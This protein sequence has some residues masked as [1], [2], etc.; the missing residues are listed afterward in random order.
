MS[1]ESFDLLPGTLDVIVLKA[2]SLGPMHGWGLAQRIE[3]MSKGALDVGQGSLYPALQ[4]LK[5][6]G[7]VASEWR[8][9]E[10]NRRARYYGLTPEGEER[11]GVERSRWG[12]TAATVDLV[13]GWGEMGV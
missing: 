11:L 2:L 3:Q 1:D 8:R 9:T 5:R 12:R 10:N 6:S 7:W 13:L 4:R